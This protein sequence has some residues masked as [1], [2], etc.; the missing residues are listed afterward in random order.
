MRSFTTNGTTSEAGD[1][2][3][4]PESAA[5]AA[6]RKALFRW[7]EV[8]SSGRLED[9]LALYAPDAILVPTLSNEIRGREEERRHYFESFLS[10]GSPRCDIDRQRSRA[11]HKLST[12]VIGGLY[13]FRFPR[14]AGEETVEA[15]FLFTFEEIEGRWLITGHHS[16]RLLS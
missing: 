10:N 9:V 1:P 15:R 5:L 7:A 8:L 4:E 13:T 16:S 11:S 2:E 14:Q 6:A 3:T 12:V